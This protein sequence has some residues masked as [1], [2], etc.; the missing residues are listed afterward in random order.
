MTKEV[1]KQAMGCLISIRKQLKSWDQGDAAITAIEQALSEPPKHW[2]YVV[3]LLV[4]AGHVTQ[5]KVDEACAIAGAVQPKA[6]PVSEPKTRPN[7]VDQ[8]ISHQGGVE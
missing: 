2:E 6:E 5:S 8:Y 7:W 1:L 3:Q 4:A